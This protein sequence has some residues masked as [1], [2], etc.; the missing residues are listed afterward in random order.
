MKIIGILGVSLLITIGYFAFMRPSA[1]VLL[2]DV[3]LP[4]TSIPAVVDTTGYAV[5]AADGSAIPLT[6]PPAREVENLTDDSYLFNALNDDRFHVL[7]YEPA[8]RLVVS[9][10]REPLGEARL[11]AEAYVQ[12][13]LELSA[14]E[15]CTMNARVLTN[16]YVSSFYANQELGFSF[17]PSAVLLP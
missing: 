11:A 10:L 1:E 12:N 13:T 2:E 14:S 5:G 8:G 7:Y 16:T 15:M 4:D 9:L 17:C 3:V 6:M